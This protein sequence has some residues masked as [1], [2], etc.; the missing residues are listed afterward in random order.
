[1]TIFDKQ[2]EVKAYLNPFLQDKKKIGFVPTMGNLHAGHISLLTRALS[3]YETV[4]FS[5]FVNPKQFGPN[6]DFN[7]YPRTLENDINLIEEAAERFSNSKIIVY[8]LR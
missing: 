2:T 7:R 6:E 1:M 4:Y 5:I 8:S 3:E